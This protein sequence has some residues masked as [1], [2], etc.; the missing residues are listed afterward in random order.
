[1][2]SWTAVAIKLTEAV[3]HNSLPTRHRSSVAQKYTH[4]SSARWTK[5]FTCFH[6]CWINI[7]MTPAWI[8]ADKQ[9]ST[10]VKVKYPYVYD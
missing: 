1:M 4:E 9:T 5:S 2:A 10:S 8:E 7:Q 3:C 6:L